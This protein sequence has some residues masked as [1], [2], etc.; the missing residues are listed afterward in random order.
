MARKLETG[1]RVF[2]GKFSGVS[3]YSVREPQLAPV[4]G[5][6]E[7]YKSYPRDVYRFALYLSGDR[8]LADGVTSETEVNR[9]VLLMRADEASCT[10]RLR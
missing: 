9:A 2:I 1:Y 5:F 4:P 6:H 3:T 7:L 10:T 8:K